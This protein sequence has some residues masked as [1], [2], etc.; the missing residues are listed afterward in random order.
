[1]ASS[2]FIRYGQW[3]VRFRWLVMLLVALTTVF[4]AGYLG[5]LKLDMD[6]DLWAPQAHPYVKTTKQLEHLFGGTNFTVIGVIPRQGDIYQP[7]VLAKVRR[8]QQGIEEIQGAIKSNTISLA[9]RKIKAI[10]GGPDGM[11]VRPIMETIPTTPAQLAQLKAAVLANPLY[12]N[13]LVSPKGDAAAILTDFKMDKLKP[14]YQAIYQQIQAVIDKE[15][16]AQTEIVAGGLLVNLAAT[17]RHVMELPMFLGAAFL[18]IMLVQYLSFRSFQG[19]LLP[20][21]TGL[22][23][24][25]WALGFM[26]LVGV[27]MDLMNTNTP[28]LIM[29]VATGHAIQILKRYYEQYAELCGRGRDPALAPDLALVGKTVENYTHKDLNRAAV[30]KSLAWIA[31]IMITAGLI[32]SVTFFSL[33]LAEVSVVRH[34]GVFAGS[35]IIAVLVLEMTLI[36]AM[37]AAFAPPKAAAAGKRAGPSLLDRALA[38]LADRLLDGNAWRILV[39]GLVLVALALAG[40][41]RLYVDNSL[42]HDHLAGSAVRINDAALNRHFGGTNSMF[43]LVQGKSDDA[44]KDP[45][46]LR[47]MA[48]LQDFL[49]RQPGVGKTTSLADMLKKMNQAMHADDPAFYQIPETRDLVAQYL[50]LFSM[51]GQPQ[52]L[53]NVVDTDYRHAVIQVLL[54]EDSTQKAEQLYLMAQPIIA[55]HFPRDV[56]VSIGGSLPETIAINESLTRDKVQNMIQMSVIV[57][58]L[59]SIALRSVVGG[60]F[61]AIPLVLIILANLGLM[62]WFGIPLDMGTSTTASMA[63]GVGADYEIYLLFRFREEFRRDGDL[64]RAT[65]TSLMTSGKAIVLVALAIA[66]GYS[67][68]LGTGFAFYI[69]FA[70]MVIVTMTVSSVCALVF[71]RSMMM[72]FKPRF[73]FGA[74]PQLTKEQL[75]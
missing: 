9:A 55:R 42:N 67:V 35:G 38:R 30:I 29:A 16:D 10:E 70:L 53:D 60:L 14:S 65:R 68:L 58:I 72:V 64:A 19:M 21:V 8:I 45:Q 49:N 74:R 62:G 24:V 52:D 40:V 20:L 31:P 50:L 48:E 28:I 27:H 36:P 2:L 41:S 54:K 66:G 5:K 73:I 17:E 71:L 44:I 47:G 11:L 63:I 7:E 6:P 61:V 4:L 12:V 57:F 34:F 39:G 33:T 26:G 22:L 51:S 56:V 1:M 13:T 69:R 43:F 32:A 3:I 59:A 23:S 46:V 25:I 75:A 18:V 37:R 15:R